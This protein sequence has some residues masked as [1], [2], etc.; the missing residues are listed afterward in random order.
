MNALT[1]LAI[2]VGLLVIAG[3]AVYGLSSNDSTTTTKT[4]DKSCGCGCGMAGCKC[5][6]EPGACTGGCS[7]EKCGCGN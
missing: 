5:S 4:V 1:I 3:A 6:G 7:Q 2:V